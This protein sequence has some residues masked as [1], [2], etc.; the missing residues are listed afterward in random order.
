MDR[1]AT[2]VCLSIGGDIRCMGVGPIDGCWTIDVADPSDTSL[3]IGSVRLRDGA[4]AT[5]SVGAKRWHDGEV[6]RH[7]VFDP[8]TGTSLAVS[9][10]TIVQSSVIAAEAVWAEVFATM[11]LVGQRSTFSEDLACLVVR[12][13]GAIDTND[14]WAE[15]TN[16]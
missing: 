12:G 1:D 3:R 8:A 15:F 10:D 16:E 5:S 14:K 6:E 2:G 9:T 11:S 13:N 7:H 4:I